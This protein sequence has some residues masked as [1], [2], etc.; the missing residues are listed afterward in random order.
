MLPC[1]LCLGFLSCLFPSGF[2]NKTLHAHLL[3]HIRAIRPGHLI[4]L[5]LI[6]RVVFGKEWKSWRISHIIST[7][8][9][10]SEGRRAEWAKELGKR[11]VIIGSCSGQDRQSPV[12]TQTQAG[13]GVNPN[14]FPTVSRENPVFPGGITATVKLRLR[15]CNPPCPDK[16]SR[17]RHKNTFH[18]I[19]LI[20][21]QEIL[22]TRFSQYGSLV[23]YV[24]L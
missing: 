11:R 7:T 4:R 19:I 21:L 10:I 2:S 6:V 22:C 17:R 14:V 20:F 16:P 1:Q 13:S 18:E 5:E 3:S 8:I 23:D 15:G 24:P 9:N 12:V